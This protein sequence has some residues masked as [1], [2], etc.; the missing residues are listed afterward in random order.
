[1]VWRDDEGVFRGV[2]AAGSAAADPP[3]RGVAGP[4]RSG[5]AC[6]DIR[7]E[8]E[9][10]GGQLLLEEHDEEPEEEERET[11]GGASKVRWG[12]SWRW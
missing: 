5:V 12:R 7:P 6:A 4:C 11:I 10:D 8:E 9:C 1:L 3:R 2:D